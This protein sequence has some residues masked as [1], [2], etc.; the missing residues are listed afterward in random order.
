MR[1]FSTTSG[2]PV[3]DRIG[4]ENEGWNST[5]QT[6]NFERSGIGNIAA[7]KR[8]LEDLLEYVKTTKRGGR[9]LYE[10][11]VVR[12]KLGRLFIDVERGRALAYRAAWNQEKGHLVFS[13]ALASESKIFGNELIQRWANFGSE[14][15]GLHGQIEE[16][17]WAPLYGVMTDSYQGCM[18]GNIAAGS[19]E[20]QR[21]IIAWVG[22]QLPRFP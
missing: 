19:S 11:P 6:M 8:G 15:M 7:M 22:V 1:F 20:I 14:I 16:S 2:V 5:R 12:Q 9:Y 17:E 4:A 3:T 13:P 18:G 10:N 21:N